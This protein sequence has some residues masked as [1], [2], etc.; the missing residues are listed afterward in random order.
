MKLKTYDLNP[1]EKQKKEQP[2]IK[3]SYDY[4]LNK[5]DKG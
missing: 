2:N 1:P 5:K 4:K 3:I